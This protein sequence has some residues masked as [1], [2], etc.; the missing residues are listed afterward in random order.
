MCSTSVNNIRLYDRDV[1]AAL[2]IH[3]IA[4]G[5]GLPRELS[6]WLGRPAMPNS[7]VPNMGLADAVD[8][9]AAFDAHFEFEFEYGFFHSHFGPMEIA[10]TESKLPASST[11]K[12]PTPA[13]SVVESPAFQAFVE[14]LNPS[15]MSGHMLLE[16][17]AAVSLS[18]VSLCS[19]ARRLLKCTTNSKLGGPQRRRS[20]KR[21]SLLLGRIWLIAFIYFNK[22][23]LERKPEPQPEAE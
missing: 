12:H 11:Q 1:S 13:S 2:N 8:D 4:V 21:L 23:V 18:A 22:R 7:A 15:F 19:S 3:R 9:A 17:Y 14:A 5:P 6:S 16:E 10:K 20:D